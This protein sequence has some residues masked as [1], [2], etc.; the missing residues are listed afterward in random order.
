LHKILHTPI[1]ESK[2]VDLIFGEKMNKAKVLNGLISLS[3]L[4]LLIS[5][6]STHVPLK[7]EVGQLNLQSKKFEQQVKTDKVIA[8]V[9]PVFA[10]RNESA[11]VQNTTGM[12]PYE[13][14]LMGRQ[15]TVKGSTDF[16]QDFANNYAQRLSKAFESSIS[17]MIAAKGFKLQGPFSN[18][19]DITYR[20]KKKIYLAFVPKV[21]FQIEKKVLNSKKERLFIHE[22]GVIQIGGSLIIT[23]VEPMTGKTCVKKRI[24]L[25]DFNIKEPYL[26]DRQ[27]RE[28]GGLNF[29]TAMDK[30]SAPDSIKDTTDVALTK[31]I[32][33]FYTKAI[34]KIDLYL[35]REEILSYEKDI[36]KLKGL[37][38]F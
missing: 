10:A 4:S 11:K 6:C 21:D 25:S 24:N 17:E 12:N 27:Y 32:N 15:G 34:N 36:L 30:V 7:K 3:V 26:Q 19:D 22:E 8:I 2:L 16:K 33:E 5:G 13:A 35:D 18:F 20:E 37:K 23:M 28:G 29:A 14:M 31:A 1:Y 9:S 38:R